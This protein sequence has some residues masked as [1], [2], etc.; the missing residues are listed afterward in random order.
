MARTEE[1]TVELNDCVPVL[2]ETKTD[3]QSFCSRVNSLFLRSRNWNEDGM[4]R[5]RSRVNGTLDYTLR[6]NLG[7]K[8][9]CRC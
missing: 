6:K 4:E 2:T 8:F 5:L 1:K 9:E 7:P 3:T